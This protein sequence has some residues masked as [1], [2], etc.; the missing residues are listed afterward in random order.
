MNN[1]LSFVEPGDLF[2]VALN[3]AKEICKEDEGFCE[4][5]GKNGLNIIEDIYNKKK[6]P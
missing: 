6:I 5:I 1:K 4:S 3:E 2:K